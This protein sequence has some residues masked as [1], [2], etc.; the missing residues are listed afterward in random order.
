MVALKELLFE[1]ATV[2]VVSF[3]R[4]FLAMLLQS[5]YATLILKLIVY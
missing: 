4:G 3:A 2:I 1:A 5:Y